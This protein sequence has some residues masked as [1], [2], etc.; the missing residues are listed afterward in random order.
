[1]PGAERLALGG[2][3]QHLRRRVLHLLQCRQELIDQRMTD[4]V[5]LFRAA[6]GQSRNL[7]FNVSLRVVYIAAKAYLCRLRFGN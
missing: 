1:M 6:Q 4:R 2:H 3:N 7:V 5:A